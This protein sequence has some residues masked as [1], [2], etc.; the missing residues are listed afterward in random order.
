MQ[1]LAM[2]IVFSG[3]SCVGGFTSVS[4][5]IP[6]QACARLP[7]ELRCTLQQLPWLRVLLV[8]G[9]DG[10]SCVMMVVEQ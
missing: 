2:V 6:A 4:G 5:R 1:W 7:K 8:V 10:S 9:G 3:C